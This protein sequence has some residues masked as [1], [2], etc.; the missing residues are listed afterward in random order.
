L[1][2]VLVDRLKQVG[3]YDVRVADP[4]IGYEHVLIG[5]HPPDIWKPLPVDRF[6]KN[7]LDLWRQSRSVIVFAVACSPKTNNIFIG[8]YAPWKREWEFGRFN[9]R[10]VQSD[11]H[12]MERLARVLISHITLRGMMFLQA[13]GYNVCV[14]YSSYSMPSLKLS[15]Y[16][17]GIGV[18]GRAGFIIH[19]VLG[20]RIRLGGI[21]TDAV[22][23]PDGRLEGFDPCENCDL[24]IKICPAQAFDPAKRYPYSYAREKCM[25]KRAEIAAKGLYCHNCYA[26]CPAGKLKDER[27]LRIKE[28]KSIFKRGRQGPTTG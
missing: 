26:V 1:K 18:Y 13:Q 21:L 27:L 6:R 23:E 9:P 7:P 16:E 5:R 4:N 12:A 24:C 17:A 2:E 28:A 10:D 3:A 22:L 11:K 20:S 25:A 14:Q 8:P 19:P 15:A